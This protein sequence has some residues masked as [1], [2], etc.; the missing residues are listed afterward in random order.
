VSGAL[1]WLWQHL[2]A[3]K[4]RAAAD[5]ARQ[6][7]RRDQAI[8]ARLAETALLRD[9]GRL[10][11]ARKTLEAAEKGV[12]DGAPAALAERVRRARK[13][14]DMVAGLAEAPLAGRLVGFDPDA[15][16]VSYR[17][18]FQQYGVDME[19]LEPAEAATRIRAS[20]IREQLIVGLDDW[21]SRVAV[22]AALKARLLDTVERAD[23][24]LLRRALRQPQA[25]LHWQDLEKLLD[26]YDVSSLRPTTVMRIRAVTGS[27]QF[28]RKAQQAHPNDFWINYSLSE[29]LFIDAAAVNYTAFL[30]EAIGF[31]RVAVALR[32]DSPHAHNYLGAALKRHG[33]PKEA[34]GQYRWAVEL[35]NDDPVYR[36][37]LGG[38][39]TELGKWAEAEKEFRQ[40]IELKEDLAEAHYALAT[41]LAL[42][43]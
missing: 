39:L 9:Q 25:G 21:E 18:L 30:E 4:S 36:I 43:S 22:N 33:R 38:V 40:A 26:H 1:F 3:E 35:K 7:E 16:A 6:A 24:D 8:E 34:E 13:D 41:W 10:G 27:L 11:E 23:D 31:M 5:A 14:L 12:A 32:P 2:Q 15:V 19:A 28:L 42:L 20:D 29:T 17:K 37:N